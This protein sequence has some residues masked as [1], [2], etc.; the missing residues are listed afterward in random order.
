MWGILD[1]LL[2]TAISALN[3]TFTFNGKS[4]SP[5]IR[6]FPE[7]AP[8][9]SIRAGGIYDIK[10]DGKYLLRFSTGINT[11]FIPLEINWIITFLP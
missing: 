9:L 4:F 1:A 6:E 8:A 3:K 5:D 10:G 11:G 2:K 7:P